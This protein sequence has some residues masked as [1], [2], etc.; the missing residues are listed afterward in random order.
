M[1]DLNWNFSLL[2][3]YDA[4]GI[5]DFERS[6]IPRG[7]AIDTIS[8]D[9]WLVCNDRTAL[10]DDAVEQSGFANVRSADD[11]D[12]WQRGV[13]EGLRRKFGPA[14]VSENRT[15]NDMGPEMSP[16]DLY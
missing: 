2:A 12:E 14:T 5:N 15:S 1:E 9:A 6:S 13:H 8:S 3:G 4:S 11:G 10:P 7:T 16:G